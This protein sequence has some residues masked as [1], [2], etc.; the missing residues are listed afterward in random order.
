MATP[1]GVSQGKKKKRLLE[2][3]KSGKNPTQ[4]MRQCKWKPLTRAPLSRLEG[5]VLPRAKP[6]T[7]SLTLSPLTLN[8]Q[9]AQSPQALSGVNVE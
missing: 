9:R 2:E 1:C 4:I 7:Q 8:S 6:E 5:L 3:L